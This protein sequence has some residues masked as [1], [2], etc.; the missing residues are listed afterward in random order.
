MKAPETT[1]ISNSY[2]IVST[3]PMTIATT[4]DSL[5]AARASKGDSS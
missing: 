5:P 1:C 2:M 3:Y 4:D